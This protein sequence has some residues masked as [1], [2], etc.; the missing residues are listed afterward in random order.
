MP[1]CIPSGAV[2]YRLVYYDP[3]FS[4]SG[5]SSYWPPLLVASAPIGTAP[6]ITFVYGICP[7]RGYA[8][9][10]HP[11]RG[12]ETRGYF[13]PCCFFLRIG[14]QT[15]WSWVKTRGLATEHL[16]NILGPRFCPSCSIP[17][18][19]PLV[20]RFRM[21]LPATRWPLRR[22]IWGYACHAS[23][24]PLVGGWTPLGF[25]RRGEKFPT[26]YFYRPC[27]GPWICR[28]LVSRAGN[29]NL[30]Q[31]P[32]RIWKVCSIRLVRPGL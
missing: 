31:N 32:N 20:I 11:T 29:I 6:V 19:I 15:V 5:R 10:P 4:D 8:L 27:S 21:I 12:R 22:R 3:M 24:L 17:S 28:Y 9:I 2:H 30:N 1:Q 26:H 25:L 14:K 16:N 13:W 23:L 18:L 7:K